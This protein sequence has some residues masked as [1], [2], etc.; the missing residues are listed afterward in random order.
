MWAC[1]AVVGRLA[2]DSI[3]PQGSTLRRVV[4]FALL[5]SAG[6]RWAPPGR[7]GADP[8]T[9]A[10]AGHPRLIGVG[11]YNALQYMAL[12]TSTPLNVTLI[13]SSSPVWTMLIG[14]LA[15]RRADPP[16]TGGCGA[17][18]ARR[19]A[20][21]VAGRATALPTCAWCRATC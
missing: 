2:I 3:G 6:R 7:G 4:A 10:G 12:R 17:V 14:A 13:A 20:G 9:L 1:N 21:A 15:W 11:A 16:A 18:A 5:P 19:R 8:R